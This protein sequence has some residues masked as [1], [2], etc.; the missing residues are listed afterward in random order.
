MYYL[1]FNNQHIYYTSYKKKKK[2]EKTTSSLWSFS[3]SYQKYVFK[4]FIFWG[5]IKGAG[6][7]S[8]ADSSAKETLHLQRPNHQVSK[9]MLLLM[10]PKKYAKIILPMRGPRNG[11]NCRENGYQLQIKDTSTNLCQKKKKKLGWAN[12]KE[13]HHSSIA[14]RYVSQISVSSNCYLSIDV[15]HLLVSLPFC[16]DWS[17]ASFLQLTLSFQAGLKIKGFFFISRREMCSWSLS[18]FSVFPIVLQYIL[19]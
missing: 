5:V 19:Q 13:T 11:N 17:L 3:D 16:L 7:L 15:F 4:N 8:R 6:G 14:F 12:Q 1:V 18:H 10:K 9:A 2:Q